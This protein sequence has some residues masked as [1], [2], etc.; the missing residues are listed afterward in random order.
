MK[1]NQ[2]IQKPTGSLVRKLAVSGLSMLAV[3]TAGAQKP[4]IIFIYADDWGYGDLSL[5]GHPVITTPNLDGMAAS[6]IDFRQFNVCNPVCSPSRTAILTGHYPA[7]YCIHQ[8]FASHEL[9]QERGMPDWLDPNAPMLP[10]ELRKSGYKT[11]HYGKWHLTNSGVYNPPLPAMYGYDETKVYNGPGPQVNVP[12]GIS[13]GA[14]VDY[15]IDFIRRAGTD[16]FFINLWIHESHAVIDPP[17]DAKEA[18][19]H[20]DEPYRSYYAC[21]SYAD[22][23]LGRLFRFLQEENLDQNTLVIFSSD[24]GPESPSPNPEAITWYSRGE[25]AGLRGQKRSLHEGGV[26]VPFIVRWPGKVP[27]GVIDSVTNIAGVDMFP[28]LLSIAGIQLPDGYTGD[29]EDLSGAFYGEEMRRS[30]PLFWEWKGNS[31]GENWPRLA[32]RNG[33]WKLLSNEDGSVKT[34][35]NI[36]SN[37]KEYYDL[38][39]F[40]PSLVQEMLQM[41]MDWKATLPLEPDPACIQQLPEKSVVLYNDFHYKQ[42]LPWSDPR[43]LQFYDKVDNPSP[44]ALHS[45]PKVG[46]IIRGAGRFASL[47]FTAKEFIDFSVNSIIKVR[48]YYESNSS[49]PGNCNVRL[50]LR[51]NGI[52]TTQY[53]ITI[54]VTVSNEWVEYSFD[55]AGAATRDTYNQILLFFSSPDDLGNT[56][57][58]IFYIDD[59]K[60]PPTNLGIR[61]GDVYTSEGGDSVIIDLSSVF[62]E[63]ELVSNT[64]FKLFWAADGTGIPVTSVT[65]D[66]HSIFLHIDPPFSIKSSEELLLSFLSGTIK[67]IEGQNLPPFQDYLVRQ[68]NPGPKMIRFILYDGL[69]AQLIKDAMVTIGEQTQQTNS[70]GTA[71]F[72]LTPG[73]QYNCS[74]YKDNYFPFGLQF[75]LNSDTIFNLL[76]DRMN[77]ELKFIV[78]DGLAA[79]S[80]AEAEINGVKKYSNSLGLI[81]FENLPVNNN[82]PVRI[83]HD[84][85]QT[86]LSEVFLERDTLIEV[87]LI[88]STSYQFSDKQAGMSVIHDQQI[89]YISI[90]SGSDMAWVGLFDLHG[91]LVYEL[92]NT[93]QNAGIE[94]GGLESGMYILRIRTKE[95]TDT[96][97][98]IVQ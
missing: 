16:P 35:Y 6:G 25:T 22:R 85:F 84:N 11:A 53:S 13:T 24:N 76:L 73:I 9:N 4:N 78:K 61:P 45:D 3:F 52:T 95:K 17:A 27:A 87:S 37:R 71:I 64:T 63:L 1:G 31:T 91:K 7:R 97:K 72:F 47:L 58:Q 51:N 89:D 60:G 29:G 67:D 82:Y 54:P 43:T 38:A 83:S 23:E 90:S 70:A 56:E 40:Y 96:R 80:G 34:L 36:H 44:T 15:S 33:D 48:A 10:R 49:P 14:C 98:I 2:I 5:H 59:L 26:G 32:V 28:T 19:A 21:I 88:M 74:I 65:N 66:L 18:Y 81:T 92:K 94:L 62:S 68:V 41:L 50:I 8:H 75:D 12:I 55:C 79:I 20:I 39:S 30:G 77:C 57:G 93:G 86:F 42:Y 46:K 69:N